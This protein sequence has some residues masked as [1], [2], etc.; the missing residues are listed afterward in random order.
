MAV[1][2]ARRFRRD[3]RAP[4]R[5][6][7]VELAEQVGAVTAQRLGRVH[8]RVGA[9]DQH[10]ELELRA[11]AAGDPDADRC[12]DGLVARDAQGLVLDE[13]AQLLGQADGVLGH[14]LGQDQHE[15]LAPVATERVADAHP[16]GH[17]V[18]ELAQ[19][20]V[21]GVVP[22]GVV[23][24]LEAID[25]DEGDAERLVMADRS[26]DLGAEHR[27]QGLAVRDAGQPVMGGARLDLEE[28]AAGGV[29]G[30]RQASLAWDA[31]LAQVDRLV[32]LEGP[33][34]RAARCG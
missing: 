34:Q 33:L 2:C 17:E 21:A 5:C 4:H 3:R 7:L 25:V 13:D 30:L 15:L 31:A 28:G 32:G 10:V 24:R 23:D 9:V 26:L 19:H 14:G 12:L 1:A 11:A 18:G 22:V 16:V 27:E 20:G 29:E 8:G 6:P